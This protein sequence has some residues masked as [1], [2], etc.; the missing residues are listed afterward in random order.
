[1]E[2]RTTNEEEE[3][4]ENDARPSLKVLL[5]SSQKY[6]IPCWGY[7]RCF[8]ARCLTLWIG[9]VEAGVLSWFL[10]YIIVLNGMRLGSGRGVVWPHDQQTSALSPFFS[11]FQS[12][13]WLMIIW[14]GLLWRRKKKERQWQRKKEKKLSQD[15]R[16]WVQLIHLSLF[17][18]PRSI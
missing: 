2:Y 13:Y 1:M 8:L 18:P 4:L 14:H 7:V 6:I 12:L 9:P 17:L 10:F 3:Q 5:A 11:L 15:K 16:K